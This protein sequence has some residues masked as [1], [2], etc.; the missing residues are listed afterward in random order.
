VIENK[1]KLKLFQF[2]VSRLSTEFE[3][4]AEGWT[5]D[6]H[7][8][9]KVR[10]MM[11]N[12]TRGSFLKDKLL[13]THF[14]ATYD[15]AEET[16][17]VPPRIFTIDT[18]EIEIG[19]SFVIKESPATFLIDI[20]ANG[21]K[22]KNALSLLSFPITS[23][24]EK[25]DFKNPVD[26]QA[27]LK[28]HAKYRDTPYVTVNWQI[29]DNT[30]TTPAGVIKHCSFTG[31]FNNE[32]VEGA[33][34]KDDN[35]KIE[36]KGLVGSWEG[37]TF[38]SDTVSV[39][40]ISKPVLE[41]R[42]TSSFA[43]SKLNAVTEGTA[44]R[45]DEGTA[46]VNILYKGG[47]FGADTTQPYMYG[48]LRLLD[49]GLTY[50]P[51]GLSFAHSKATL[52]FRGS[53]VFIDDARL[54]RGSTVLNMEGSLLN[55]LNLYY[56]AP[57]KILWDWR[58]SSPFVDLNEFMPFLAPRKKE[59]IKG[60]STAL[61][62][63]VVRVNNFLDASTVHTRVDV[64]R[65][66]YKH[67]SGEKLKGNIML[68]GEHIVLKNLSLNHADGVLKLNVQVTQQEQKSTYQLA[69][70]ADHVDVKK[71]FTAFDNFG[72]TTMTDKNVG[73]ILTT[74]VDMTGSLKA[75]GNLMPKTMNGNAAFR[76]Q[77]GSL[78]NFL[79]FRLM[80]SF[81]FRRRNLDSIT[82]RDIN[83]RFTIKGDQIQIHP[84][85]I[86]SSAFNMHVKG[87]YAVGP[88]GT[89]IDIDLPLRNPAKDELVLDDELRQERS[90]NGI[91][92]HLK[93]Y[94]D[95]SGKTR[96]KW[97]RRSSEEKKKARAKR[98]SSRRSLSEGNAED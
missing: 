80:S 70:T 65:I 78:V 72:Q 57:E 64:D 58:L 6:V 23:K 15:K 21:I 39:S 2:A 1:E 37:I 22:Y 45:F 43:I 56:T 50:L 68:E 14:K 29:K 4:V 13:T 96:I 63:L 71:F 30:L 8:N 89:D 74:D 93:A 16:I 48:Y 66:V 79:P 25:F 67:F 83:S 11:F 44:F 51:R 17:V 40:N 90:L 47:V 88:V 60:D 97:N 52:R 19:L 18:D 33:G 62:K 69:A 38:R 91:V 27:V 36:I 20:K 42:F 81:V 55:F 54:Q 49:A 59:Q 61:G 41:G 53:D 86:E 35:A 3:Y 7:L 26:I 24:L 87:I 75:D 92:L 5:A 76:F 73:G 77:N 98:R 28:G 95:D 82:F 94:S 85:F 46:E 84:M 9:S 12:T 10:N 32:R 34:F 31:L